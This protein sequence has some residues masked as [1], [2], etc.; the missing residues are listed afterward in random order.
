[1]VDI[2]EWHFYGLCPPSALFVLLYLK[3]K[4]LYTPKNNTSLTDKCTE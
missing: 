2:K 3:L 4:S 1:M